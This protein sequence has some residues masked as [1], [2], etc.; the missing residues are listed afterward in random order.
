V[1]VG[2]HAV[3]IGRSAAFLCLC[4]ILGACGG[5]KPGASKPGQQAQTVPVQHVA[6]PPGAGVAWLSSMKGITPDGQVLSVPGQPYPNGSNGARGLRSSDGGL[7]YVLASGKLKI[8]SAADGRITR[9]I[10][11]P[12]DLSTNAG[13][14]AV[15]PDGKWL[16]LAT[17]GRAS[18]GLVLIDLERDEVAASGSLADASGGDS[19]RPG[20]VLLAA[21][22]GRLLLMPGGGQMV[23][24]EPLGRQL[25]LTSRVSDSRL[26]CGGTPA[27]IR[28]APAR[29]TVIGYCPFD[30]SV[31]WFDLSKFKV[32]A[33]LPVLLGNPFWGSTAFSADGRTLYIY[34][35]WKGGVNVVDLMQHRLLRSSVVGRPQASLRL[36]FVHDAYAKGP[37]FSASLSAD[38]RTLFVSG[39]HGWAGGLYG[40]DTRTLVVKAHWLDGRTLRSVWAGGDGL[41]VYALEEPGG[42]VV[43]VIDPNAG[44]VRTVQLDVDS[45]FTVS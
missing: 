9:R 10:D 45:D 29:G 38:G 34:D 32:T 1:C 27:L 17:A 14:A 24:V 16:G 35:S 18:T 3:M 4:L 37:N 23:L 13:M 6:A 36:P 5:A 33:Q 30:G 44:S 40:V 28:L 20:I 19:A 7:L 22:G 39:P 15:S 31:W 11:L 41:A 2:A 25:I 8:A 12:S 26:S 21:P 43:H 42:N